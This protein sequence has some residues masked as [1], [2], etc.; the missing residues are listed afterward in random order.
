MNSQGNCKI[1]RRAGKALFTRDIL[2]DNIAI[3]IYC[4]KIYIFGPWMSIRQ[5]KLLPNHNT[6]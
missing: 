3:K 2:T 5:G 4:D 1:S 6:R